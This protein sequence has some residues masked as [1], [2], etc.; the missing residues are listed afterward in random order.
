M[1]T[2]SC[3]VEPE[4]EVVVIAAQ[5]GQMG[6]E[7]ETVAEVRRRRVEG[8]HG[9][10]CVTGWVAVER[11]PQDDSCSGRSRAGERLG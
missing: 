4:L 6:L 8:L 5:Q 11:Y 9:N 2:A 1:T 3:G 7:P 10:K